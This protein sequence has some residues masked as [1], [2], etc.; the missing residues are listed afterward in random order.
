VSEMGE[1]ELRDALDYLT[2]F[3]NMLEL[4]MN[5]SSHFFSKTDSSGYK[6]E[7]KAFRSVEKLINEIQVLIGDLDY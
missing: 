3:K 6:W 2:Q 1:K 7:Y 4:D 5:T